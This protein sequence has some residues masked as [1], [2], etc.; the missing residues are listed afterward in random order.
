M[1]DEY[2]RTMKPKRS[3]GKEAR[4]LQVLARGAIAVQDACNLTGVLISWADV[5]LDIRAHLRELGTEST[6]VAN[7]HPIH[8]LFASKVHTLTGMGIS[9]LDNFGDAYRICESLE[10][11]IWAP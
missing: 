4:T 3:D 5:G 10:K 7:A 6:D 11:G 9:N 1:N 2:V 8:R